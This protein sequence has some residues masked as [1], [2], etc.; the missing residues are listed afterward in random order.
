MCI[1]DSHRTALARETEIKRLANVLVAPGRRSRLTLEQLDEQLG[2]AARR[3][4]LVAG[5][6]VGW[7][8]RAGI[9]AP[10]AADPDTSLCCLL[11]RP[12]VPTEDELRPA[13]RL[14]PIGGAIAEVR[15][16]RVGVDELARIHP[17]A[18]I[19]HGLELP[20]GVDQL[21]SVHPHKQ[22]A[23]RLSVAVL[24]RQG[25]PE[26]HDE[27]RGPLD[28]AAVGSKSLGTVEVEVVPGVDAA[29]TEVAVPGP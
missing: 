27:V 4:P 20:E 1:R 23:A 14:R 16:E 9:V 28:E 10:A 12:P 5:R 21:G 22:F 6:P 7:A 11:E 24:A 29:L 18:R 17:S 2:P 25:A 15:V 3:V 19:E 13:Q 8:H 26:R